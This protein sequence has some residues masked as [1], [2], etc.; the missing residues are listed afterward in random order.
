MLS[1][2]KTWLGSEYSRANRKK[3]QDNEKK[4]IFSR[5]CFINQIMKFNAQFTMSFFFF[6]VI[7]LCTHTTLLNDYK[8][9]HDNDNN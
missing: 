2:C 6:F 4:K 8:C 7:N 9:T 1:T 3:M 5:V